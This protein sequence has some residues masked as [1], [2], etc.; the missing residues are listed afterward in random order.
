MQCDASLKNLTAL[1]VED[2]ESLL[3]LLVSALGDKFRNYEIARDGAEGL[4]VALRLKPD[5]IISD[6]TM[7]IMDGLSMAEE[8]HKIYTNI[9]V[10]ILSAYSDRDKLLHAI[11]AG[12][13]KYFIK[14][15]D[16]DELLEYLCGLAEKI[17]SGQ[18]IKLIST[19][20]FDKTTKKLLSNGNIV[21][22]TTRELE[23]LAF[24]LESPNH[25]ISN[26]E[27]KVLIGKGKE[28][29]DENVRVFIR[30]LRE[31]TDRGII[32]NLPKQGYALYLE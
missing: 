18:K 16:P 15:F 7:P 20:V 19:F 9:P 28:A 4:E 12:V 25:M 11:E 26:D 6:I 27:I 3:Q 17:D 23:L 29:T 14:P 24:L 31:K 21:K 10:I 13:T 5:I 1:F 8:I 2:E 32:Q 22:L 30:R